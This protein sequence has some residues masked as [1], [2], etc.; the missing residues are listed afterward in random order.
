MTQ[1]SMQHATFEI[2]RIYDASPAQVFGSW[3]DRESKAQWFGPG[4]S[5][6]ELALDF[7]VGGREHFTVPMPD[8]RTFGYDAHYHEIVPDQRITYAYSVDFDES[9][10]SVSLVTVEITPVGDRTRLR[11]TEQAVY[12]DGLDTPADREQGTLEEFKKLDAVL[13][14]D[15][16]GR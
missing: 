6:G 13:G 14:G 12:L 1:R 15:G 7:R 8:G 5:D 3:A 9:R 10:I 11:Y 2:G 4:G 16:E